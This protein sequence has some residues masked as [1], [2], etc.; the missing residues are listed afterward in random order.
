MTRNSSTSFL[1]LFFALLVVMTVLVAVSEAVNIPI[2]CYCGHASK[3]EWACITAKGNWDGG[4]CGCNS[5]DIYNNFVNLCR[6][7]GAVLNCWN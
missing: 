2:W 6:G 4:S 3:T 7:D 5:Y 1:T